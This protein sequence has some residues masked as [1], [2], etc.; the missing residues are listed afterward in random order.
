MRPFTEGYTER[1]RLG[2]YL[3]VAIETCLKVD[4]TQNGN[5]L[6][7][8]QFNSGITVSTLT[9]GTILQTDWEQKVP[10]TTLRSGGRLQTANAKKIERQ[11][12]KTSW[13]GRGHGP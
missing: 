6:S 5:D 1:A 3:A 12:Q 2:K 7:T 10:P 13:I 11:F 9:A 8:E 4:E